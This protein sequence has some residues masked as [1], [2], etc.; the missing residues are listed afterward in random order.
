MSLH[1]SAPPFP[2][3]LG[4]CVEIEARH[5]TGR[6]WTPSQIALPTLVPGTSAERMP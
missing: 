2:V 3:L 1:G 6:I 4:L 5:L